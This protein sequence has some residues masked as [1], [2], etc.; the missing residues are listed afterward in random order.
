MLTLASSEFV[1][2]RPYVL[3]VAEVLGEKT[4]VE[5]IQKSGNNLYSGVA[6]N[7][8]L[9][10]SLYREYTRLA[11]IEEEERQKEDY[12][13]SADKWLARTLMFAKAMNDP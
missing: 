5:G 7:G 12:L 6:G 8:Y 3:R 13:R 10:H 9:M 4:W 11:I 2:L 1:N